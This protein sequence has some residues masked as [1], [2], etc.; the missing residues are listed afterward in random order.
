MINN[1]YKEKRKKKKSLIRGKSN[2]EVL[3]EYG[4][5]FLKRFYSIRYNFIRSLL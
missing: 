4:I 1:D 3:I 2:G 5:L